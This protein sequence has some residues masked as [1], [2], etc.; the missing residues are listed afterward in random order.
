MGIK[1]YILEI[2][3]IKQNFFFCKGACTKCDVPQ[4]SCFCCRGWVRIQYCEMGGGVLLS[5]AV[6]PQGEDPSARKVGV[7]EIIYIDSPDSW[8]RS[9]VTRR[10]LMLWTGFV[11]DSLGFFTEPCTKLPW[12]VLERLALGFNET[13]T[14]LSPPQDLPDISFKVFKFSIIFVKG[15]ICELS[16][17]YPFEAVDLCGMWFSSSIKIFFLHEKC[18]TFCCWMVSIPA[19]YPR[20]HGFR[21]RSGDRYPVSRFLWFCSVP[22]YTFQDHTSNNNTTVRINV[23]SYTSFSSNPIIRRWV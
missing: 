6:K 13:V 12:S 14:V 22:R 8:Q 2:W 1:I 9:S 16:Y 5:N 18:H 15:V 4:K 19:L 20:D 7:L 11:I 3:L 23:L 21:S 10:F 17:M